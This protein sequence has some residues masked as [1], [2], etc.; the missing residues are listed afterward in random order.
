MCLGWVSLSVLGLL[1]VL[2]VVLIF[3]ICCCCLSVKLLGCRSRFV[4]R[5]MVVELLVVCWVGVWVCLVICAG[6]MHCCFGSVGYFSVRRCLLC[7]LAGL[8]VFGVDVTAGFGFMWVGVWGCLVICAGCCFC[9]CCL[10]RLWVW[11]DL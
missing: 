2:I 8:Y 9:L 5:V 1:F 7:W 3:A 6:F 10:L 11:L 4:C